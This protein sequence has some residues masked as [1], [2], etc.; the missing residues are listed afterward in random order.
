[1][2]IKDVN[3]CG[4]GVDGCVNGICVNTPGSY[5][6]TACDSGWTGILCDTGALKRS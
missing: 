2:Y 5:V 3:E 4:T 1:M 6:C